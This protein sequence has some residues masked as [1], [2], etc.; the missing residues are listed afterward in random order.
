MTG[1]GFF[2]T[3]GQQLRNIKCYCGLAVRKVIIRFFPGGF[4][5]GKGR[6]DEQVAKNGGYGID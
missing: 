4:E 3:T 2:H 1:E 5:K 6:N